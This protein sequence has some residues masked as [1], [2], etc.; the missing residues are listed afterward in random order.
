MEYLAHVESDRKQK[1]IDHLIGSAE[2][3]GKFA[4]TFNAYEWGYCCGLL[5]DIGKYSNEFQRKLLGEDIRVDHSTAGAQLCWNRKG[6]YSFLSYCIAG[7]HAGLPDTGECA[8]TGNA[9]SLMGRLKKTVTDYSAFQQE[10]TV[11]ELN[12]FPFALQD[13]KNRDFTF[14]FFIRMLYSCLVDA[15]FLNT[16]FFMKDGCVKREPGCSMEQLLK[17]L[18]TGISGWLENTDLSTVNGRRTEI[19]KGCMAK[20]REKRGLFRLTVPTGGG[21]TVASLAFALNHAV[22]NKLDRIIYVIPYTSIIEQNAEVF[23]GFLGK[24]NV[25]EDHC[26]VDYEC[27]EELKPMQLAAENWDKPVVVTTNVQFFESLFGSRSSKCRKLH[28]IVNSVIIFD[29]AQMLPNDYL[30]PCIAAMEELIKRYRASIVLCT[31][32]QPALEPFFSKDLQAV[33][34]CP[35]IESQFEFFKRVT[36]RN[37]GRISEAELINSLGQE[38]QALCIVN[39]KKRAQSIYQKIRGEGIYHLSTCMYPEHRRRVLKRIR[40][41][42]KSGLKCIVISTSLVEAGVDLDFEVVYRQLAGS[43]FII[44]AAGRCNREGKRACDDSFTYIFQLDEKEFMPGQRQQM[45]VAEMLIDQEKDLTSL[46]NI[47]RYFEMLYHY[48][49]ES[50]DKKGIIGRFRKNRYSFAETGKDFRLIE[51]NTETIFINQEKQADEILRKI[52]HMGISKRLMREAGKYCVSV[53]ENDFQKLYAAGMLEVISE[54]L[55]GS[56]WVLKDKAQY[57][58]EMGLIMDVEYGRAVLL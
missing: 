49:S 20:G 39:T 3:A 14:S 58:E 48:R 19:L 55:K 30:K 28:N 27:D 40:S 9:S 46:E 33:E 35:N 52:E 2:I 4:Q 5:H 6:L 44:Q 26:N 36:L 38:K 37:M 32:T 50:L 7:H 23:S 47:N 51:N 45:A 53:Y 54:E 21:K 24:E 56:F 18:K 17:R 43:D 10:V 25:L 31:A 16:E 15:D 29:E 22:E 13:I 1:L 12:N 8:D 41:R 42:L 57:S 34:L 11:P